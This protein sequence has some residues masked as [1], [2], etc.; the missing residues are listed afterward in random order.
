MLFIFLN[1]K[2][3]ILS[4]I[5]RTNMSKSESERVQA[6][7]NTIREFTWRDQQNKK[8]FQ[9]KID[10][11]L[12]KE[13]TNEQE[14]FALSSGLTPNKNTKRT[15]TAATKRKPARVAEGMSPPACSLRTLDGRP[16]SRGLP[17][18]EGKVFPVECERVCTSSLLVSV[19]GPD[20]G[21]DKEVMCE[22]DVMRLR[23][24]IGVAPLRN[25]AHL[26]ASEMASPL[27]WFWEVFPF[28]AIL[29]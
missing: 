25:G 7:F 9:T 24:M 5:L 20:G 4:F 10:S 18:W 15:P 12:D 13:G 6:A 28:R 17:C 2:L 19:L 1:Q 22:A 26:A 23:S 8:C 3:I 16:P 14:F 29:P 11:F 21:A 27:A